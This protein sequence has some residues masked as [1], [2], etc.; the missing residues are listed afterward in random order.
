MA[1]LFAAAPLM[2]LAL[3]YQPFP[4]GADGEA[5]AWTIARHWMVDGWFPAFP[6]LGF[7]LLGANL[8]EPRRRLGDF[9]KTA[10]LLGSL[11]LLIGGAVLWWVHP[12]ELYT[13]GGYSE[14]FYPPT[15][16]FMLTATGV[17]FVQLCLVDRFP[18]LSL[19]DP[20]RALGQVALFIYVLHYTCIRFILIPLLGRA[21]FGS[22]ALAY[23]VFATLMIGV[24]YALRA[25]KRAHP[26]QGFFAR[27]LLGG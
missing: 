4:L 12:G 24:A 26:P 8:A 18:G 14:M 17:V 5:D 10:F 21:D 27:F 7:A 15:Y 1:A 2:Q 13:R 19:F 20:L 16:G 9:R 3:G 22:Y 25:L 23:A 11:A 6:W